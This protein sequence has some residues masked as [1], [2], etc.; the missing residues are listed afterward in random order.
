MKLGSRQISAFFRP[1]LF[2]RSDVVSKNNKIVKSYI[3]DSNNTVSE[4]NHLV[5][6]RFVEIHELKE[7]EIK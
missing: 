5:K 7:E 1:F 4:N 3:Y 6:T 2:K